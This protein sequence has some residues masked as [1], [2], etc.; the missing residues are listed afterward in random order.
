MWS[1]HYCEWAGGCARPGVYKVY[2][3]EAVPRSIRAC[4]FHRAALVNTMRRRQIWPCAVEGCVRDARHGR[5]GLCE[6]CWLVVRAHDTL[7]EDVLGKK[8]AEP[9]LKALGVRH[10]ARVEVSPNPT[11][12]EVQVAARSVEGL[13]RQLDAMRV[14]QRTLAAMRPR[15]P[16]E[17]A[18]EVEAACASLSEA[19]ECAKMLARVEVAPPTTQQRGLF[20]AS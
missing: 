4:D 2:T 9:A 18:D 10:V 13:T 7:L 1:K 11:F 12:D 17:L 3:N 14:V 5:D 6:H 16:Q 15:L 20:D 8:D 19:I